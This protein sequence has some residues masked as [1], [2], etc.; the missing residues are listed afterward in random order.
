MLL[1][2]GT[3]LHSCSLWSLAYLTLYAP[4][5]LISELRVVSPFWASDRGNYRT[6]WIQSQFKTSGFKQSPLPQHLVQTCYREVTLE[7]KENTGTLFI[8][9]KTMYIIILQFPK[10]CS[11]NHVSFLKYF[12]NYINIS[13]GQIN[14]G[15]FVCYLT[16]FGGSQCILKH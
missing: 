5:L 14:I 8:W 3:V 16:P 4:W 2:M 15:T 10:L 6:Q 12:L 11:T 13:R 9:F 7:V 1:A